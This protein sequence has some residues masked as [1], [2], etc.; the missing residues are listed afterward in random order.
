MRLTATV[1][2]AVLLTLMAW[3]AYA[4]LALKPDVIAYL[5]YV[6]DGDTLRVRVVASCAERY[7]K[8]V[9]FEGRVRLADINAPEVYTPEG[10][11]AKHALEELLKGKRIIYVDV[12]DVYVFD[13]YGRIVGV[14][15]IPY[16]E[17]HLLVVNEWLLEHGYAEPRDY[18]NEFRPGWPLY[19]P[20]TVLNTCE[21]HGEDSKT[22]TVTVARWETL[23]A[24][25]TSRE[26]DETT[27][28]L[29]RLVTMRYTTTVTVTA[30]AGNES[31]NVLLAALVLAAVLA[32]FTLGRLT[33]R[34]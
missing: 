7:E 10:L 17:S 4:A 15:M 21:K 28:S 1:F 27:V 26:S 24:P 22:T 16:N 30:P 33:A 18:P 9:G 32:G 34:R 14:V 2:L 8:L 12:D 29:T 3:S 25:I 31:T 13:R 5:E 11:R 23:R 20:A 19:L 6:V